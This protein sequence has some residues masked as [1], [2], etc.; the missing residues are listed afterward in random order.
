MSSASPGRNF[1]TRH[2]TGVLHA[3]SSRKVV[4]R[5]LTLLCDNGILTRAVVTN[6]F[7]RSTTPYPLILTPDSGVA[8]LS[9]ELYFRRRIIYNTAQ[10]SLVLST[11]HA[12]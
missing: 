5:Q 4:I 6:V 1:K 9:T 3:A 7:K 10:G 8:K 2:L 12:A 11:Y